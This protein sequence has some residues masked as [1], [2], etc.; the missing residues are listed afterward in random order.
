[1][2]QNPEDPEFLTQTDEWH[3]LP[4]RLNQCDLAGNAGNIVKIE[5]WIEQGL[6]DLVPYVDEAKE[7]RKLIIY[8][9]ALRTIS[10][11]TKLESDSAADFFFAL[12]HMRKIAIKALKDAEAL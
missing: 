4:A 5:T 7:N 9:D 3:C 6:K 11:I 12:S 10:S 8:E 1:M 2:T